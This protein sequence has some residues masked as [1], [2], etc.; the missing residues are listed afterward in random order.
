M[1]FP[2][3]ARRGNAIPFWSNIPGRTFR[4]PPH[5]ETATHYSPKNRSAFS[6]HSMQR[7]RKE[8]PQLPAEKERPYLSPMR[9]A[10]QA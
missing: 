10:I 4:N 8:C 6:Q 1:C 2:F 5:S 7:W 3:E 9:L